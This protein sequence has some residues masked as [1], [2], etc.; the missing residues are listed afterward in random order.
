MRELRIFLHVVEGQLKK[1]D[2]LRFAVSILLAFE[3][4]TSLEYDPIVES[5]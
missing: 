4:R 5:P 2:R 1:T 3:Q